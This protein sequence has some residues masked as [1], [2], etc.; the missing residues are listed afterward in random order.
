MFLNRSF[1]YAMAIDHP[2]AILSTSRSGQYD[3]VKVVAVVVLGFRY[4]FCVLKSTI[5]IS[6][7]FSESLWLFTGRACRGGNCGVHIR[8]SRG[9]SESQS[10]S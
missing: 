1:E 7:F 6:G 2:F 9:R 10:P 8:S 3:M 4:C 5:V